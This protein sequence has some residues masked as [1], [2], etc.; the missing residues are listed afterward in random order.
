MV[1]EKIYIDD[2]M[3]LSPAQLAVLQALDK[4]RSLVMTAVDDARLGA[5]AMCERLRAAFVRAE[6]R[7]LTGAASVLAIRDGV[8]FQRGQQSLVGMVVRVAVH[9]AALEPPAI[10]EIRDV[11]AALAADARQSA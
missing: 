10:I 6:E 7:K 2:V 4:R 8:R 11:H 3:S 5:G 1:W 9:R